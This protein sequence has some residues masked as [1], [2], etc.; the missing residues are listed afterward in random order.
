MKAGSHV[1]M[2]TRVQ[3]RK[4]APAMG[5]CIPAR[6]HPGWSYAA[7]L[8]MGVKQKPLVSVRGMLAVW[9]VTNNTFKGRIK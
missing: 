7:E 6:P 1:T 3:G 2:P 8:L 5:T 4:M 9:S